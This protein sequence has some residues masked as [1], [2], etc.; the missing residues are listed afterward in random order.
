[1]TLILLH[2]HVPLPQLYYN[3]VGTVSPFLEFAKIVDEQVASISG[4]AKIPD[5]KVAQRDL[6]S[7]SCAGVF[8]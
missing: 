7:R 2:L 4:Y 3:F 1:M 6:L 5:P 8:D